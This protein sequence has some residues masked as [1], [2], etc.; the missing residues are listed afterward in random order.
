MGSCVESGW[1]HRQGNRGGVYCV[2]MGSK[3]RAAENIKLELDHLEGSISIVSFLWLLGIVGGASPASST[4]SRS[5]V[6]LTSKL[7]ATTPYHGQSCI[8]IPK[9]FL[10]GFCFLKR[11]YGEIWAG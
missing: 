6:L 8:V 2:P 3:T 10:L 5:A 9:A 11:K 1:F 4:R 7:V